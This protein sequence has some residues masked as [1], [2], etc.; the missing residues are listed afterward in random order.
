M[1]PICENRSTVLRASTT[2]AS[3]VRQKKR[4]GSKLAC[5]LSWYSHHVWCHSNAI[6]TKKGKPPDPWHCGASMLTKRELERRRERSGRT[7]LALLCVSCQMKNFQVFG[8][9]EHFCGAWEPPMLFCWR[10]FRGFG[11]W[12]T[13]RI[14]RRCVMVFRCLRKSARRVENCI[15]SLYGQDCVEK[16]VIAPQK[17]PT[18]LGTVT[19]HISIFS[20]PLPSS[21]VVTFRFLPWNGHFLGVFFRFPLLLRP[22]Q[23]NWSVLEPGFECARVA[24]F[25]PMFSSSKET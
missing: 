20:F 13:C 21:G 7:V 16:I 24:A 12:F 8:Q 3:T 9:L 23:S 25:R 1:W 2:A 6:A 17:N 5:L 10:F 22:S 15:F 19:K 18:S 11:S 14:D 4:A